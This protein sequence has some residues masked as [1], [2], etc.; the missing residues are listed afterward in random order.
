MTNTHLAY[1]DLAIDKL[2]G[3]EP[4]QDAETFIQLIERKIKSALGYAPPDA[5][6]LGKL[7]FQEE[8]AVFIFNPRTSR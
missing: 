6:D 5:G 2:S 3:T 4:N 8:S 1:L 7:Q